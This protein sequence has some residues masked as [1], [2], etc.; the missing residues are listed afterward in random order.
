M[1]IEDLKKFLVVAQSNNLHLAS[2]ELHITPGALSKTIRRIEDRLNT[3]LF[4]RTGRN[5]ILNQQGVKFRQYALHLVHEAEQA[6]SEFTGVS[7]KTTVNVVGPSLILQHFLPDVISKVSNESFEFNVEANWEGQ[8]LTKVAT[9]QSHLAFVTRVAL[10]QSF[11]TVDFERI[12]MGSSKFTVVASKHH[13]LFN[14]FSDGA[15]NLEQLCQFGFACPDVSPFCGITRGRGSDNWPDEK[16]P[17][18]ITYR[19]NDFS[20]LMSL[21]KNG[22]AL[23]YVPDF[24]AY[25]NNLAVIDVTDFNHEWEEHIELIYKPSLA[26]GWLN[27]FA[28]SVARAGQH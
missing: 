9:G 16:S 18:T 28:H 27:R 26:S 17:R 19:C 3:Q 14:Q 12:A 11:Y 6:I 1:D 25:N 20:V 8:A 21:V 7:R 15:L 5:I 23:A 4:D 24:V 2:A 13:S 22:K 10:D